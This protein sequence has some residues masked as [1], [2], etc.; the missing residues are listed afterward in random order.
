[1]ALR[2]CTTENAMHPSSSSAPPLH[3]AFVCTTQLED[4]SL[5]LAIDFVV[6]SGLQQMQAAWDAGVA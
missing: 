4:S 1:M 2:R 6:M 5:G 3:V